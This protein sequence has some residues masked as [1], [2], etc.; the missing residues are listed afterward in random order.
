ME[1]HPERRDRHVQGF[2]KGANKLSSKFSPTVV[3]KGGFRI[4][5]LR[6]AAR[7]LRNWPVD[8]ANHQGLTADS[9]YIQKSKMVLCT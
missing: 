5:G 3:A 4:F 9:I 8:C 7:S 2:S 6:P 1:C